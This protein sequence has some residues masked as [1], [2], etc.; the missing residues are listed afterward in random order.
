MK[1]FG[2]YLPLTVGWVILLTACNG[3]SSGSN[4]LGTNS[5]PLAEYKLMLSYAPPSG[6]Q[7]KATSNSQQ[8]FTVNGSTTF[9]SI[10]IKFFSN[11]SC[12]SGG[13]QQ[14]VTLNGG[15]GVT[16][17]AGTYTSTGASNYAL[18]G[19]YPGG[20]GALYAAFESNLVQSMR[21]D[22]N[23]AAD[24]GGPGTVAG[25]C[26]AGN[27]DSSHKEAVLNWSGSSPWAACTDGT[28]CGFSQAYNVT[29]P[30]SYNGTSILITNLTGNTP[31]SVM[32]TSPITFTATI[33]G[34]GS[35]TLTATLNNSVTG[36]IVSDPSPCALTVGGT[37]S[38]NFTIIPWFTGF[39]N[40][41]VGLANYDPFTPNGTQITLSATNGATIS[42]TGV[43]GNTID[44]SITTPYVYLPASMEGS[45]TESNTGITWGSGGSVSPRFEAGTQSGGGACADSRKD[46]LTGL[47]WAKNG[48]IGFKSVWN[49]SPIAQPDYA[50]TTPNLNSFG[51][52]SQ[53]NTAISNMNAATNKLCGQSD[54]RLPTETELLSL[55]NYSAPDGDLA[56]WL[57]TQ[58][59]T[60]IQS[61]NYWSVTPTDDN[62][63]A[64]ALS[65]WD[66]TNV[67]LN[68]NNDLSN[69]SYVWPVRSN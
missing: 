38:C 6:Q 16:F 57:I 68:K 55:V 28:N 48:I 47:E 19:K 1:K 61:D 25:D 7:V 58:G 20:C 65:M 26:M 5:S 9:S 22:Y 13:L 53:A 27:A 21:F 32:G 64:W 51:I 23:Y 43:S 24:S 37:T 2:L 17:P 15:S 4:A 67:V 39:D 50:N 52:W 44:Y 33:S 8:S 60:N 62:S 49:G 69:T 10:E 45:A 3:N 59:F 42:G 63:L 11:N 35:S 41:T 29:L 54:W 34:V 56:A 46:N 14:T 18:C 66:G 12:E 36:T 31:T 30:S 40:S